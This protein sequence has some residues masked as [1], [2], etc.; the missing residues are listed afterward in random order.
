MRYSVKEIFL[1]LQGEGANAGR[2]AVR[3]TKCTILLADDHAILLESLTFLLATAHQVVGTVTDGLTAIRKLVFEGR[4]FGLSQ[5][6][7]VLDNNFAKH[8]ELRYRLIY[9]MPKYGNDDDYVD[10]IDN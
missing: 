2:A 6:I 5:F 1:T 4:E 3:R 9:K 7:D 8:E 10:D